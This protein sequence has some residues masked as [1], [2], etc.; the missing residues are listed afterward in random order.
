MSE[1]KINY[2]FKHLLNCNISV[3]LVAIIKQRETD[4]LVIYQIHKTKNNNIKLYVHLHIPPT[5]LT[6]KNNDHRKESDHILIYSPL[7]IVY[8]YIQLYCHQNRRNIAI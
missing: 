8:L 2:W 5:S 7:F 4:K 6:N 3:I 1:T